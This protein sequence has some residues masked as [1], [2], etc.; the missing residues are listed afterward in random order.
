MY[1][2]VFSFNFSICILS[3]QNSAF[4]CISEILIKLRIRYQES[5]TISS[6]EFNYCKRELLNSELV[7]RPVEVEIRGPEAS[8]RR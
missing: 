6:L 5:Q 1:I 2:I 7:E 8:G 4:P 3:L